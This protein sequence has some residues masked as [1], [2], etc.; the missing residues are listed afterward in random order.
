MLLSRR[1]SGA[2]LLAAGWMVTV[3]LLVT[4]VCQSAAVKGE[5]NI[6]SECP[7]IQIQSSTKKALLKV[8]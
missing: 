5:K 7:A 6:L 3:H 4:G 2:N 1:R 8:S